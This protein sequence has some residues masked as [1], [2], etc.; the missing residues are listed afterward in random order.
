MVPLCVPEFEGDTDE[1]LEFIPPCP[2]VRLIVAPSDMRTPS[3][4]I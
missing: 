4:L 2:E 1:L 3:P